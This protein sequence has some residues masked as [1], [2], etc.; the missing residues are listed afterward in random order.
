MVEKNQ[1]DEDELGL[2]LVSRA[3]LTCLKRGVEEHEAALLVLEIVSIP[4]SASSLMLMPS[5][6]GA[7][8][9]ISQRARGVSSGVEI[10]MYLP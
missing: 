8:T 5:K 9:S 10:V 6:S 4:H 7:M 2:V 3:P 1:V